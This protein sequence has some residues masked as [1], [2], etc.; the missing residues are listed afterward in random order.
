MRNLLLSGLSMMAGADDKENQI[1]THVLI[2]KAFP[3]MS[4]P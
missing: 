4:Y 3:C 1:D 2:A